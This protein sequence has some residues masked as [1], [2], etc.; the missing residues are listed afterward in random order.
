MF[1]DGPVKFLHHFFFFFWY[2]TKS[3]IAIYQKLPLYQFF[4]QINPFS[5][6]FNKKNKK[7]CL[8]IKKIKNKVSGYKKKVKILSKKKKK[9]I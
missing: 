9:I 7:Y 2:T 1:I 8:Y 4:L 6:L 5:P 3:T